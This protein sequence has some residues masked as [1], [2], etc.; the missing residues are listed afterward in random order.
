MIGHISKDVVEGG[1]R[2]GGTVV[3]AGAT[4]A[5]LG[6]KVGVVTSTSPD[7]DWKPP[8]G[9]TIENVPAEEPT[10]FENLYADGG[11]K[12]ML[13]SRALDL[14]ADMV[15][16][17]WLQAPIV[18]LAPIADEVDPAMSKA[19]PGSWIALSPQGW[20]RRW[21]AAGEVLPKDIDA[22]DRLPR[23]RMVF[24]ST[25]DIGEQGQ[26]I[27]RLVERYRWFILT[28]GA[29]GASIYHE[30]DVVHMPA[31]EVKQVDP[32]GAGDI[33]AACF[34][35]RFRETKDAE[36]AGRFANQLASLSVTRTGLSSIPTKEE[37]KE[38]RSIADL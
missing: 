5:A 31:P 30:G 8:R 13:H 7:L 9:L 14:D 3:Y 36:E 18:L 32:T 24:L 35:S 26:W 12:Q 23:A 4:L 17:A 27:D 16:T 38:A 1:T 22:V 25:E 21:N 20:L 28:D 10:A 11:R 19:F 37:I 29:R 34:I 2:L 15:P 33:F 6:H